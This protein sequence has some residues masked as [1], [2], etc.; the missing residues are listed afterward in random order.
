MGV[1]CQSKKCLE[2]GTINIISLATIRLLKMTLLV[3]PVRMNRSHSIILLF[4]DPA[5]E[6]VVEAAES[7]F[8]MFF[9]NGFT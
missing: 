9:K 4:A 8:P 3:M 2:T 1:S 7:W 5:L 6:I